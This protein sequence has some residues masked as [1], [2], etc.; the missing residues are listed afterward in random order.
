MTTF[1]FSALFD[2]RLSF[3]F[4]VVFCACFFFF[5]FFCFVFLFVCLLLFVCLYFR[6][7]VVVCFALYIYSSSVLENLKE[8]SQSRRIN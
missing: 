7:I 3:F 2:T 5:F 1:N 8:S 6:G 4:F